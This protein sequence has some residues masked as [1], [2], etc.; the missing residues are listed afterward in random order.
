MR[1]V[2]A[3][4][5]FHSGASTSNIMYSVAAALAPSCLWGVYVFGF[6]ALLVLL[7]SIGFAVL[8]EFL[9]GKVSKE[10]TIQD[11]S[12]LVT[13]ILVGMNMSPTI[14]LFIPALASIFAIA[15]VKWTFGGL[16]A[17]WA[18]PAIAGR[19]FVF[20]SFSSAMSS[21]K[22]PRTLQAL[23]MVSSATPLSM[24]KTIVSGG[25]VAGQTSLQILANNGYM[26]TAFAQKVQA[27]T[28]I[29]AYNVDAFIG[30]IPGCIGEVSKLLLIAGGIYLLCRKIITWHIPVSYLGCYAILTWIFGGVPNGL[31]FFHG[32]VLANL[33]RG[34][35]I[36]GALFM[37]TDMVT[38]PITH[39]GMLI[40]G[41]GC[42]FFT[43]LFRTFGSLPEATSVAILMMNIITPTIDR[44]CIPKR[45]GEV[46]K[47][48]K[49]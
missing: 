33:L 42:G 25:E 36:L 40:F 2:S 12:A 21:F 19:V 48:V 44:F 1:R 30:N 34:G 45:F 38:S 17:N 9:L 13:G 37:A 24:V 4:P 10:C 18:N 31:G 49:K 32:E 41:A 20:F 8:T 29:S 28:G 47:E 14:P 26:A 39:K 7:V 46:V 3:S 16:G 35:L 22:L 6:R 15:V 43:F 11:G 23:D 5:H 27:I